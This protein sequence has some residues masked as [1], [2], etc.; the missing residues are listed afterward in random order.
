MRNIKTLFFCLILC[1]SSK[2]FSQNS[3]EYFFNKAAIEYYNGNYN[4]ASKTL[5][6]GLKVYPSNSKLLELKK[7]LGVDPKAAE[8]Q[9]YNQNIRSLENQG[10]EKGSGANG[11]QKKSIVDPN[12]VTHVYHKTITTGGTGVNPPGPSEGDKWKNFNKQ[13]KSILSSG[14]QQGD[15]EPGDLKKTLQDPDGEIHY[16]FKKKKV[17]INNIYASFSRIGQNKVKWS[18]DLKNNAEKITIVFDNGFKKY[19]DD[20]TNKNNY[21]F[22]SGDKDFDGVECTV[23]LV[24]V[25]K[26]NV[27]LMDKPNLKL[28]THC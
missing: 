22:V 3:E 25:L 13:E 9:K 20:V 11:D 26:S 10:F 7:A 15:G 14:Y 16:Y 28:K 19:T 18:D 27:K 24:I 21:L 17:E 5:N 23:T 12:G 1:L 4:S 8:W 6:E 2:S